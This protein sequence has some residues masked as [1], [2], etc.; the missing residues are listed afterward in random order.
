MS[1]SPPAD[2]AAT[3][4][5][6][7]HASSKS[8]PHIPGYEVLA[9]L[10]RGGMGRVYKARDLKLGRLV[11]VKLL[12]ADDVPNTVTRFRVEAESLARLRHPNIAQIFEVGEAEG[13]C[14]YVMELV[15]S[16][17]LADCLAGR[18]QEPVDAARLCERLADAI[19]HCHVQG[20]LHRDLKPA[21]VLLDCQDSDVSAPVGG[22]TTPI[23][24]PTRTECVDKPGA[25]IQR[26]TP[27][28]ADFGLAKRLADD[29]RLTKTGEVVGTPSYMAPE[30]A[31]GVVTSLGPSVDIYAL[32]AILYEML[33]GRPPFHGPDAVQTMLMVLSMNPVAPRSLQPRVPRDLETICLKCLEKSPRKRYPIAQALAEDLRRFV[34]GKPIHARPIRVWERC[35]KWSKRNKAAAAL[36]GVSICAAVGFGIG[37]YQLKTTNTRLQVAVDETEETLKVARA[38]VDRCL[39]RLADELAPLPQSEQLR[40]ETLEDA[41]E[42]YERLKVIRP[43][44][45]AGRAH[46]A[47]T[48]VRLGQIYTDLGRHH[49]SEGVYG[50][51]WELY[52]ELARLEPGERGHARGRAAIA[53]SLANLERSRG[54]HARAE[55]KIRQALEEFESSSAETD[56][57]KTA[58]T[59][60]NTLALALRA[61]GDFAGAEQEHRRALELRR[62]LLETADPGDRSLRADAAVSHSNLA[63]I[64]MARKQYAEAGTE[65]RLAIALLDGQATPKQRY[66]RGQ[67]QANLAVV[68]EELD[69]KT[70][71]EKAHAAAIATFQTLVADHSSVPDYRHAL[72]KSRLNLAR[73]LAPIGRSVDAQASLNVAQPLLEGLARE[74]PQHKGYAADLEI[75][76]HCRVLVEED[77]RNLN[78]EK[79]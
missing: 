72:A 18:P 9:L 59:L 7:F 17:S 42:L 20:I 73:Y 52:E 62:K 45:P 68:L 65:L 30:Q 74:F 39:A 19:H 5:S 70:E 50:Q 51:A 33:V 77:L 61:Q 12:L 41:R 32:G 47:E 58:A 3:L 36:L 27:K 23:A 6:V 13:Q 53:N 43:S 78:K 25:I 69:R 79:P 75:C 38:A 11:A 76:R 56:D 1:M 40:R 28:I 15:E 10:G 21:N 2:D 63:T 55:A 29:S 4:D 14:F 24:A 16:G 54:N 22:E 66:Y 44:H 60:H 37:A 34:E 71:I 26:A 57:L 8:L 31:S 48:Q 64:L 46:L 67:V 35:L 49:D